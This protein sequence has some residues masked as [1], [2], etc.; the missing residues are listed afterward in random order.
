MDQHPSIPNALK[1]VLSNEFLVEAM[2]K[3]MDPDTAGTYL[4]KYLMYMTPRGL[5]S[6]QL[7]RIFHFITQTVI[8]FTGITSAYGA[9]LQRYQVEGAKLHSGWI[10]FS[11]ILTNTQEHS[12]RLQCEQAA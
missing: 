7:S 5:S 8:E 12:W 3:I 10:L 6:S 2:E 9:K 1:E 11:T 4:Q